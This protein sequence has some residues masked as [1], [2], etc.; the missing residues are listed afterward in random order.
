M[1]TSPLLDAAIV[2]GGIAGIVHLHYA[3]RAGLSA[4]VFEKGA[5]VGGLWRELPAWQD[6]QIS[7]LDWALGD[8]PLDGAAQPQVLA[9]IEAWVERFGLADGIRLDTPVTCA[10]HVGDGWELET[11]GGRV[12]ARHLVAATGGHNQALIPPVRR[13]RRTPCTVRELHSSALRDPAELTGRDVVVV[14]GGASAFDL[15]DLCVEHRARRIRWV[16]RGVRW[17]APTGK[18]KTVAGSVRPYARMQA[19]GMSSEQ[20]NQAIGAD[21][22]SRY[23]KFGLRSIQ[24][25]QPLDVRR[26]QL[27]PDR[28]RMLAHF[29]RLE[30][31]PGSVEEIDGSEVTLTDGTRLQANLLL[32][33]TG[34]RADLS[35]FDDP[36]LSSLTSL[37]ALADRCA[38]IFRSRDAPDLYFPGVIL[39]GIGAAPLSYALIA[40]SIMSH[41]RGR[42]RLDM[43]PLPG[44]VNH[45]ELAQ[46][47]SSR[48]PGSYPDGQGW[49]HY[50]RQVLRVPEDQ[51]YPLP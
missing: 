6:I 49:D 38:G 40:R 35:Y 26:D 10:R 18:P 2:G 24:P 45:L 9:N 13:S 34:Y 19:S 15:L 11:A 28:A 37:D 3:R 39:D 42:A 20:Q 4:L 17:F 22:A 30:R 7:P 23:E 29:E 27:I 16:Y 47:L 31:Y 43:E 5:A 48:D 25:A 36:R 44:R 50:R 12:R 51:A 1:N 46:Y 8:L 14:G 32:W 33:G 41:I 21:L